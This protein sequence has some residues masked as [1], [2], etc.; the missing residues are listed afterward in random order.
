MIISTYKY[1]NLI[2]EVLINQTMITYLRVIT[3]YFSICNNKCIIFFVYTL[4][5]NLVGWNFRWKERGI[6]ETVCSGRFLQC[7]YT[8]TW[9]RCP[10]SCLTYFIKLV[11]SCKLLQRKAMVGDYPLP[12]IFRSHVFSFWNI[13]RPRDG[14]SIPVHASSWNLISLGNSSVLTML[15]VKNRATS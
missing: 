14:F 5:T 10:R 3:K 13:R 7:K 1:H 15:H 11:R 4:Y 8:F 2:N 6:H 12:R 9:K